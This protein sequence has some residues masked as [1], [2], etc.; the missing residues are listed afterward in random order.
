MTRAL[1][2]A[3]RSLA[4]GGRRFGLDLLLWW[5][6]LVFVQPLVPA[7]HPVSTD[8]VAPWLLVTLAGA[9]V[10]RASA[11]GPG[12]HPML[13]P[14]QDAMGRFVRRVCAGAV[15]LGLA[16]LHHAAFR[17]ED[18]L[19]PATLEGLALAG[20][21][22]LAVPLLLGRL[23]GDDGRT[24]W[25]PPSTR[26][27]LPWATLTVWAVAGGAFAGLLDRWAAAAGTPLGRLLDGAGPALLMG[28]GFLVP[29]LLFGR[30]VHAAQRRAAGRR[31][32][33][34]PRPDLF[35]P[36]LAFFGPSVG[37]WAIVQ[38]FPL[39]S[40]GGGLDYALA[41]VLSL[42][43]LAWAAILWPPP[44]PVAIQC[45]L[46]EVVPTG[47][48]DPRAEEAATAFDRPPEGAL[49][50]DPV[51][52]A[53]TRAIHPWLVPVR[54]SRIAD[55]DDP[56]RPLW[57]RRARPAPEHA[58]G[59]ACFEPDPWTLLPQTRE[60]TLHLRAG[61]DLAAVQGGD[62]QTRR[63]VVLRPF[64]PWAP[65]RRRP[66]RTY[67]WEDALPPEARQEVDA[68]TRVLRLQDGDVLVLSS[69]GVARAFLVEI[70]APIF[71]DNRWAL[72]R[73]P[74]L[75]DYTAAP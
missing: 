75:E 48:A 37:L 55:V 26:V 49:R 33:S 3:V 68:T 42:H 11:L 53:P 8:G 52:V 56:V 18:R 54:A 9:A 28:L 34:P 70:G 27:V 44:V 4:A 41:S 32:G 25:A 60:I 30:P 31:D 59:E 40:G 71:D 67:R 58:L 22:L 74:S 21:V 7:D 14:R 61:T 1:R 45:L 12:P 35:R 16:G 72:A 2:V 20:A 73:P 47:G 50:L 66:W 43:V 69:E 64:A 10:L 13:S 65:G 39:V 5:A 36:L 46:H 29:G 19:D 62:V 57:E 23:S 17:G 6:V 63:I 51:A 15:P 38:V 24:A